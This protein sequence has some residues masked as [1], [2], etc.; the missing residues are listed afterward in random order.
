[1]LH[2]FCLDSAPAAPAIRLSHGER[3]ARHDVKELRGE[4]T[5]AGSDAEKRDRILSSPTW[6]KWADAKHRVEGGERSR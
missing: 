1:M 2:T 6:G 4:C 5:G 3:P